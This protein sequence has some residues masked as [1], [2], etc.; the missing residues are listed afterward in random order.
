MGAEDLFHLDPVAVEY[1]RVGVNLFP[2]VET[3]IFRQF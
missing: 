3:P 1:S 2:A